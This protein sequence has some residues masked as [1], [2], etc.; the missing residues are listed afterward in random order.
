MHCCYRMFQ[1]S[2]RLVVSSGPTCGA[3]AI[4]N[5]AEAHIGYREWVCLGV[6]ISLICGLFIA[7]GLR[8]ACV[9]L[10]KLQGLA[11]RV[12][13]ALQV[14][15]PHAYTWSS[16]FARDWPKTPRPGA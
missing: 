2:E 9:I 4:S 7:Q 1:L 13:K 11:H 15:P 14:G 16:T 3:T 6:G 5:A 10:H 12:L 8:C